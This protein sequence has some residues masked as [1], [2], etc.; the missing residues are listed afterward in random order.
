MTRRRRLG[1][2]ICV[3]ILACIGASAVFL[4]FGLGKSGQRY[5]SDSDPLYA[6]LEEYQKQNGDC[7]PISRKLVADA[8][9]AYLDSVCNRPGQQYLCAETRAF[10]QHIRKAPLTTR[11]ESGLSFVGL[12]FFASRLEEQLARLPARQRPR[13]GTLRTGSANALALR[14]ADAGYVVVFNPDLQRLNLEVLRFV[15]NLLDVT[16]IAGGWEVGF[17]SAKAASRIGERPDVAAYFSKIVANIA[18]GQ[19][20]PIPPDMQVG[21]QRLPEMFRS[22]SHQRLAENF[23]T[24]GDGFV[25]A[26][27]YAHALLGHGAEGQT[28]FALPGRSD[29]RV[30]IARRSITSEFEADQVGL[31]LF[32][33]T[34][35]LNS[36]DKLTRTLW[37]SGPDMFLTVVQLVELERMRAGFAGNDTHPPAKQR[38]ERIR[39]W[40]ETQGSPLGRPRDV[41]EIFNKAAIFA[42]GKVNGIL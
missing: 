24:A 3:L 37:V 30:D 1:L 33:R 40:L 36:R 29:V 5:L 12:G 19:K 6:K 17:N 15:L 21:I 16:E 27:E 14:I 20:P 13:F 8:S 28:S 39:K 32:L 22:A 18:S 23:A 34:L 42:W 4:R 41:G 11:C 26:H 10:T 25:I 38:R 7:E 2:V 35:A 9:D 31:Q